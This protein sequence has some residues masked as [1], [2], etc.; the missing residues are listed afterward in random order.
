[1]GLLK[2]LPSFNKKT[3]NK[4]SERPPLP[5]SSTIEPPLPLKLDF[6]GESQ[7]HLNVNNTTN[8]LGQSNTV[9]TFTT[10]SSQ[11]NETTTTGAGLFE[12]IFSELNRSPPARDS[13]HDD[14]S[15]AFALSE[16]LQLDSTPG[17]PQTKQWQTK[18]PVKSPVT[19]SSL[20]GK[21][22]IYSSYLNGLHQPEGEQSMFASLL[23]PLPDHN[24]NSAPNRQASQNTTPT[25]KKE[26]TATQI[27]LD[28]DISGTEDD[29]D[30][31]DDDSGD[32]DDDETGGKQRRT[33]GACPIMERRPHDHRLNVSRKV[34]NWAE[35][36]EE[37]VVDSNQSML[38]R[39]KDRHRQ[40]V[41]L[42]A[43]RQQQQ[44]QQQQQQP[45]SPMVYPNTGMVGSMMMTPN[46]MLCA[47]VP[48][49]SMVPA[50]TS[51]TFVP[52]HGTTMPLDSTLTPSTSTTN[53]KRQSPVRHSAEHVS[54]P[55]SNSARSATNSPASSVDTT[56]RTST[57]TISTTKNEGD[58]QETET[59]A[60]ETTAAADI[61]DPDDADDEADEEDKHINTT[62]N[63]RRASSIKKAS[64]TSSSIRHSRSVP[65]LKKK[66]KRKSTRTP[67][68]TSAP[69]SA[70]PSPSSS[71]PTLLANSVMSPLLSPSSPIPPLPLQYQ[72]QQG[73]KSMKSDPE[74]KRHTVL[75]QQQQQ[76]QPS[77][78]QQ[79]QQQQM[80]MQQQQLQLEW[81]RMQLYQREQQLKQ[82]YMQLHQRSSQLHRSS[83]LPSLAPQQP[84]DPRF[85]PSYYHP[86]MK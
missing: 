33:L 79:Q 20:F 77:A 43:L 49:I 21:D 24:T 68:T 54:P 73:L 28:S 22:S 71:T 70:S 1:M 53:N 74:L 6:E 41:K 19:S 2:K 23:Q 80:L 15:L 48:P 85:Y 84:M 75:P 51:A 16:Q 17:Q 69:H 55:T 9:P 86:T 7:Q 67:T 50:P 83:T 29:D 34:D 10:P 56:P 58:Q 26:P 13:L 52:L 46:P 27:V 45:F 37:N 25:I 82:E 30:D 39:M 65:D 72:Q 78:Y 76:F 38:N 64:D 57:T 18:E 42:Q 3:R 4:T 60:V 31:D 66:N 59:T 14:I 12:D 11:T 32:D 62:I 36:I 44:K 35:H 8:H 5:S 40:Q 63:K 47:T 81:E 61:S